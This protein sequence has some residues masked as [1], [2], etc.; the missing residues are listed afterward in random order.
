MTDIKNG[1]AEAQDDEAEDNPY[2]HVVEHKNGDAETQDDEDEDEYVVELISSHAPGQG[3][4]TLYGA[5]WAG[6]ENPA[7]ALGSRKR[8]CTLSMPLH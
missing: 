6:Y 4:T 5:K 1:D 2:E 7:I 8:I 3:K